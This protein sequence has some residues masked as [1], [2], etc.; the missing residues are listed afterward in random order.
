MRKSIAKKFLCAL[1][2]TMLLGA[3]SVT[4]S[5]ANHNFSFS[6]SNTTTTK[7]TSYYAKSDNSQYWYITLDKT[8][9]STGVSNTMSSSNIFGCKMH[10]SYSD[11]VDVYHTFSNYVT[12]Y[13]IK[14]Q[15]TVYKDDNM[16]LAGKKDNTSSSS[17]T[18]RISGRIAP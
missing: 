5:A 4:A 3:G 9:A 7:Y 11:S 18:L 16:R 13:G 12:S 14:Y 6:F 17:A 2:M 1:S 8:N 15:T 10:R